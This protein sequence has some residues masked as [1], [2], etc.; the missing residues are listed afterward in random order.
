M[1]IL[2]IWSDYPSI[3]S[4]SHLPA[5]NIVKHLSKKNNI[6]LLCFRQ[7]TGEPKQVTGLEQ[8]C[9]VIETVDIPIYQS[10]SYKML[11][12]T[13]NTFSF[14]NLLAKKH[15]F[16]TPYYS[17]EMCRKFEY[18][19]TH[20]KF[21]LIY[22]DAVMAYLS[23]HVGLPKIAHVFDC[24]TRAYFERYKNEQHL[25]RKVLR[26]LIYRKV[27]IDESIICKDF[28]AIIV[29][30]DHEKDA[31]NLFFPRVDVRVIPNG[32]DC[33]Y[34]KPRGDEEKFPSLVFV[35]GM[36]HPPNIEGILYFHKYIYGHIKREFPDVRLYVVGRDPAKEV[37]E[38]TSDETVTVTGYVE[39][40]R[41]YLARSSLVIVPLISG[42]G[43]KNKIL[44]AMAM[45]KTVITTSIGALGI[46]V[47]PGKNII[48][49]DEPMMFAQR[50]TELLSNEQLRRVIAY[51]ARKFAETRYS[52]AST[53]DAVN[54]LF[55]EKQLE[56]ANRQASSL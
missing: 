29:V 43:M 20:G 9:E 8:H 15:C 24:G 54:K 16:F 10:L 17:A 42:S 30:A 48:I 50:V 56:Y 51:E 53:A 38:L 2:M 3:Y 45:E 37:Q 18:I 23:R 12:A 25:I 36:S 14:E 35:G 6:T 19:L 26:W 31:F 5:F 39:D 13:R 34:F 7:L 33:E 1:N 21:D 28:D 49:A 46:D 44:E 27:K 52:W 32:V 22:T 47:T 11:L 4:G 41:P 55:E 40:V